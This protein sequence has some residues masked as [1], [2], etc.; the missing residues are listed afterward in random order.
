M[1]IYSQLN[2]VR[3]KDLG[4]DRAQKLIFNV[5]TDGVKIKQF[6]EEARLLPGVNA[7]TVS[8]S[9]LGKPIIQDF[10]V[11]LAGGSM[12]NGPD[13]QD[14]KTDKYFVRAA[15][16]RLI[17]G[18]DFGDNDSGRVLINETL[19]RRL[20]LDP[21][22]APGTK[23]YSQ[24]GNAPVDVLEIVGVMK[25]INTGSLH[26][27]VKPFML[28]CNPASPS[29]C[30][31]MISCNSSNFRALLDRMEPIWRRYAP[32][33]PFEFVFLDEEVQRQY[34]TEIILANIIN[35]F[36]VMAV[37]IS[38]LGLFGLAAFSAEQRSKEIGIRKVLGMPV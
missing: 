28:L 17:S 8:S 6:M 1:I 31:V 36:T 26:E 22:K 25:D 18:H 37:V 16:I 20:R 15:G 27:G 24:Y 3:N 7:V 32:G 21:V 33:V 9:Q 4:Y 29:L 5:Y 35:C 14:I 2:Y 30:T 23:L 10:T 12:A 13:V 38:C 19:A 11:Y 34:E